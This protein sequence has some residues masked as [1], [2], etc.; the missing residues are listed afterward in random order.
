MRE[1]IW[2]RL[3][4]HNKQ[5]FCAA[6]STTD[7]RTRATVYV[8]KQAACM[9]PVLFLHTRLQQHCWLAQCCHQS[10]CKPQLAAHLTD[11]GGAHLDM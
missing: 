9:C 6:Q 7:H 10:R 2:L 1:N 5:N 11:G 3:S 8:A 4:M